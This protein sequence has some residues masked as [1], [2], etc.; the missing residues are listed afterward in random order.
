MASN[1]VGH[2]YP[3]GPLDLIQSWL[4]VHVI[5]EAGQEIYSSGT[6]DEKNFL[7]PGTFLFKA[8]P[9]DQ[10]GNLVDRHN[11][12]EMVGVRFRRAI[13]PGYSDT[14]QYSIPCPGEVS[15]GQKPPSSIMGGTNQVQIAGPSKPGKYTITAIL[16]YRKIDQFLLNYLFEREANKLTAPVTEIARAT[17]TVT[18][19]QEHASR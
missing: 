8:E 14:V 15:S 18:V 19:A 1:K 4:E 12:W 9:V 3:T 6:R 2:D 7:T 16:E 10:N 11:L 13:F 5:N 17:A